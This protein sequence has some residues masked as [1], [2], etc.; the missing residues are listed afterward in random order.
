MALFSNMERTCSA[1]VLNCCQF[2]CCIPSNLLYSV[3]APEE[4]ADWMG[5]LSEA[6][7][8]IKVRE[9]VVPGTHDSGSYTIA[10]WKPFSAVGRTQ[11]LT[12]PEQLRSGA[13]YIDLR[14]AGA[15][16]DA[17]K[18]SI[19]H[20]CL[21]GGDLETILNQ[22][23]DF[24][25]EHAKEFIVLELVP[26]FGRSLT[27][28]Q[29]GIFLKLVKSVFGDMLYPG[30]DVQKLLQQAT[31][32]ELQE[33]KKQI[34]VLL[35]NRF[36]ENYSGMTEEQIADEF[37]YVTSQKWMRNRW[38]NTKE[39]QTLLERNLEEQETNCRNHDTWL[40]NQFVLTPGFGGVS[41]AVPTL[42]G[43]NSLQPLVLA[44]SLYRPCVLDNYFRANADKQWNLIMLDYV[45]RC[46]VVITYLIALNFPRKLTIHRA[47]VGT[48]D[49]TGKA[50]THVGRQR[51]LLLTDVNQDLDCGA[52]T[53]TLTLA[54]QVGG[55]YY[56]ST[57]DFDGQ[58]RVLIS[59]FYCSD[60][61]TNVKLKR[62]SSGFVVN[63]ET[64][65]NR[66]SDSDGAVIEFHASDDGFDFPRK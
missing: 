36:Y 62:G 17:T 1:L 54:Y 11:N 40:N 64:V 28:D 45:D 34:V 26:E 39:N 24:L 56:V 50:R 10:G 48:K 3:T 49:V 9:L 14:F 38:H 8:T 32:G 6:D 4:A 15:S 57:C 46:P 51:V 2:T 18:L 25:G 41:E 47:L 19:W 31:L 37:G 35:H 30:R 60:L 55:A 58:S 22:I 43:Q 5:K 21:E 16:S 20:G 29:K 12:I 61:K 33:Q 44:A 65:E 63:G 53:G 59:D 13:R 23:K 42:M 7:A 66:P 27:D 52:S